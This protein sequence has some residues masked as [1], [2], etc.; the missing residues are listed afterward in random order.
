MSYLSGGKEKSQDLCAHFI[1]ITPVPP[2]LFG[3]SFKVTV[4]SCQLIKMSAKIYSAMTVPLVIHPCL[5]GHVVI[6]L[7]K[8][9]ASSSLVSS[10]NSSSC[11]VFHVCPRCWF[12]P[13][14]ESVQVRMIWC[15]WP[16]LY[17]LRVILIPA[18]TNTRSPL[19]SLFS[20]LFLELAPRWRERDLDILVISSTSE[21]YRVLQRFWGAEPIPS[22]TDLSWLNQF[23]FDRKA[24]TL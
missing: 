9:A 15:L 2:L 4:Y 23:P 24:G 22:F 8:I 13:P 6:K 12:C 18:Q 11:L 19:S 5:W 1:F 16:S 17:C 21:M 7:I 14:N 20:P 10:G 3:V